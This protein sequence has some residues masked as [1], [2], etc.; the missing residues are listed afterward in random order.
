MNDRLGRRAPASDAPPAIATSPLDTCGLAGARTAATSAASACA[1]GRRSRA[2]R[3]WGS[4]V[5]GGGAA[6]PAPP[7]R[8]A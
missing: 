4:M 1:S 2:G 5:A 6:S 7:R 8:R 3:E